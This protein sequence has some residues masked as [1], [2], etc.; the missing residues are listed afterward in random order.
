MRIKKRA[1][2]IVACF[3]L[4]DFYIECSFDNEFS[5]F[6][7]EN[8]IVI[9]RLKKFVS[10]RLDDNYGHGLNHAV[11]VSLDAGALINIECRNNGYSKDLTSKMVRLAQCA[12]LLHDIK[13]KEADHAA[14]GSEFA[15]KLLKSYPFSK[16][17]SEDIC[18]AIRCHEAYTKF[19]CN[20]PEN[21]EKRLLVSHCLYDADKFRWGPDNF[22][23][24]VWDMA[25]SLKIPL[26][27]FIRRYPYGMKKLGGIRSTFRSRPGKKYGPQFIDI[28]LAIGEK[29][30]SV[31]KKE[32]AHLI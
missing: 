17:E 15:R 16:E 6:F 18:Q 4:P 11:K 12:G 25:V 7:F 14:A 27:E 1:R 21:M 3:S 26:K 30:F 22:T 31:I 24:T 13:R 28:G 23:D 10:A 32:F 2:H 9:K 5:K 20:I 19:Q 29:L 8:D